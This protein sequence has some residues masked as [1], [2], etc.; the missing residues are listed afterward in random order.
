MLSRVCIYLRRRTAYRGL[1]HGGRTYTE[2]QARRLQTLPLMMAA[3]CTDKS[4]RATR[5][6]VTSS[7]QSVQA[8]G[9]RARRTRALRRAHK[10][11]QKDRVI[12]SY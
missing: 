2:Q 6:E 1:H 5:K 8:A 11:A 4:V 7:T 10:A 3:R 12:V 9:R